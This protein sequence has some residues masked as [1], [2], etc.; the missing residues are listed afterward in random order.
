MQ[1]LIF[2]LLIVGLDKYLRQA[3]PYPYPAE[4]Q[5]AM[6]M[7]AA[8]RSVIFPIMFKAFLNQLEQ[9]IEEWYPDDD[10]PS[11]LD[12]R[13]A[14]LSDGA[15]HE[16]AEQYLIET[17]LR[18]V[19]GVESLV[20]QQENAMIADLLRRTRASY[21][22]TDNDNEALDIEGTYAQARCF[23]IQNGF[24]TSRHIRQQIFTLDIEQ[25]IQSMYIPVQELYG[26]LVTLDDGGSPVCWSCQECGPVYI[27]DGK[28]TS[29]KPADCKSRCP[30][31]NNWQE[32]PFTGDLKV[33]RRGIQRR[34]LI[35]GI[36]E[37]RLFEW[38][39]EK[40][41]RHPHLVSEVRIYPGVDAYDV[42]LVFSEAAGDEVWAVDIKDY[43]FPD[44]LALHLVS[45][46]FYSGRDPLLV[47]DRA[48]YI[49]PDYHIE[50]NP[51]YL[52]DLRRLARLSE[53][54]AF[55]SVKEWQHLVDDKIWR[56]L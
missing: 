29:I 12:R 7:L 22:Q 9:P 3:A 20:A 25:L 6:N 49:I 15:L 38:L 26:Q 51:R 37:I 30:G 54:I 35:P 8:K 47:Y 28:Q 11:G 19:V 10:L 44:A 41:R 13:F 48:F 36:A 53:D 33:L 43:H 50:D 31:V 18:G 4:L 39:Q 45:H 32:I 42:R 52:D 56:A 21:E 2:P 5:H 16:V 55:Y 17:D 1:N 23:L 34:T 24:A 46:P 14:I 40:Q 27:K